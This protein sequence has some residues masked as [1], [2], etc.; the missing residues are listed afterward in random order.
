MGRPS[1]LNASK[2]AVSKRISRS[3]KAAFSPV[4]SGFMIFFLV[5]SGL[6]SIAALAIGVFWVLEL[7]DI[8]LTPTL[9]FVSIG[10]LVVGC[11]GL[12][13]AYCG[14]F[15]VC[16]QHC[17]THCVVVT[18]LLVCAVIILVAAGVFAGQYSELNMIAYTDSYRLP[19]SAQPTNDRTI[20]WY[21]KWYV[22]LLRVAVVVEIGKDSVLLWSYACHCTCA[23]NE[24][25]HASMLSSIL[26]GLVGISV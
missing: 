26:C 13:L 25:C 18:L 17:R 6:A 3:R 9:A 1:R 24:H 16:H 4:S 10:P 22:L 23:F 5:L 12:V 2:K 8:N 19:L 20:A 21:N 7:N 14:C 11:L 15:T